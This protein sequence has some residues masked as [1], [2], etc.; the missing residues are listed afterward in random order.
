MNDIAVN[1]GGVKLYERPAFDGSQ[2]YDLVLRCCEKAEELDEKYKEEYSDRYKEELEN[3]LFTSFAIRHIPKVLY[4][5]RVYELSTA[6]GEEDVKPY[7]VIAGKKAL[8]EHC[9]RMGIKNTGISDGISAGVY[10]INYEVDSP[11]V[12]VIIPNKDHT[13]DLDKA[14]R[15]IWN[16]SYKNVEFIVVENNSTNDETWKYYERIQQEIPA[17]KVVYYKGDFN[18][19][20]INNFGVK[21]AAGKYLLF[22]NNDTEM[23]GTESLAEMVALAQQSK[24]GIVGA[25]LLYDDNTLQHAGIVVGI[26][27]IAGNVFVAE[28]TDR[29][30]FNYAMFQRDYSSV[31]AAVLI[32]S[33]EV[34]DL[35]GGFSEDLAV[36]F[37]DVD[38]CLKVRSKGLRVAYSPYA[39]FHHY[40]SKSRGT[41]E[42][43]EKMARFHSEIVT[44]GEKW[45]N[46]LI[47]G[48][49]Y[50]NR[51][52]T[53]IEAD[54][55]LKMLGRETIGK[56]CYNELLMD[57]ILTT[58]K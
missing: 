7:T 38:Y 1:D 52:L 48:D 54:Y 6:G 10:R 30:Y 18:Y 19:S 27:G 57:V 33:R 11:L 2:D 24:I 12:S 47:K 4:H 29:T 40:E 36:A 51:N 56:P 20:A 43:P 8:S 14:I 34:Y 35:V 9:E 3:G 5:W 53:L 25:R 15:S 45:K 31:T 41:D 44:F 22:L 21:S 13:G 50:Y 23:F 55:G 58:E 37:N 46:I 32:S 28:E 49:P 26:G 39:V 16:G 17:V 42:A